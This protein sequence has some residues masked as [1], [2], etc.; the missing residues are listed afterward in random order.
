VDAR[1]IVDRVHDENNIPI[2]TRRPRYPASRG[3]KIFFYK[4]NVL[5]EYL[6]NSKIQILL[7]NGF[8]LLLFDIEKIFRHFCQ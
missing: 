2:T 8:F 3:G 1:R 6:I 5:E 7:L 4:I